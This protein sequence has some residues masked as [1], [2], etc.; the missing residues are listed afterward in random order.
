MPI[1]TQICGTCGINEEVFCSVAKYRTCIECGKDCEV[2]IAPTP[3][4]GIVWSNI[5]TNSQ[6]GQRWETN[7]Q[8]RAWFDK[9]PNVRPMDVGSPEEISFKNDLREQA[10]QSVKKKGYQD[11]AHFSK[12]A[13]EKASE[14]KS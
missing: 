4:L 10:D 14:Q 2:K 6:I 9:H 13:K 7:A 3:T 12:V 11:V 5:E 1:Y 8:K